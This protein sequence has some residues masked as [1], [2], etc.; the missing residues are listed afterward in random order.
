M[1]PDFFKA[2][3]VTPPADPETLD[4]FAIPD[5]KTPPPIAPGSESSRLAAEAIDGPLRK[6][7]WRKIMLTL[8]ASTKPLSRAELCE[9]TGLL[10]STACARLA[11]LRPTFV[12]AVELACTSPSGRPC[13]GYTLTPAGRARLNQ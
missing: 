12:E 13:D 2:K 6:A 10:E 9:R 5:I 3:P 8:A 11:E 4:L 1:E 7:S